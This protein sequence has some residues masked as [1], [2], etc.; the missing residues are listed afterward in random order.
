MQKKLH[1]L[2]NVLDR[3]YLHHSYER[4]IEKGLT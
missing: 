2:A 4:I 3:I 1:R